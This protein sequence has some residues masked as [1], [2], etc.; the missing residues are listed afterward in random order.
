[1]G[2]LSARGCPRGKR[3]IT[4]AREDLWI[5]FEALC[6]VTGGI[7]QRLTESGCFMESSF[8]YK[9]ERK[10]TEYDYF[11][12][13]NLFVVCVYEKIKKERRSTRTSKD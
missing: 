6:K 7:K 4:W 3:Q 13:A 10:Q 5:V 12:L 8:E 1:M 11:I 2:G 9:V